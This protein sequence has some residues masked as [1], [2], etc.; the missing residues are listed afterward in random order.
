M[1]NLV[2]KLIGGLALT[3]LTIGSFTT[4][5]NAQPVD[6]N[7]VSITTAANF[8]ETSEPLKEWTFVSRDYVYKG[9]R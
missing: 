9:S 2:S 1:K 7:E 6:M 5:A 3:A 8:D 4:T